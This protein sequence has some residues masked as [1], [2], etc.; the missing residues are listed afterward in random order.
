MA[1][2]GLLDIELSVPD[3]TALASFWERRGMILTA[4]DVLG[5]ADRPV[6]LRVAE[7]S[8]RHLSMLHL[9]CET[10]ADLAVIAGR[11]GDLGVDATIEDT[12]LRCVDPVFGHRVVIDVGAPPPLSPTQ[13]RAYNHPGEQL[14]AG[15]RA[16]AVAEN[17]PRPP[18]RL[19]HVVLGTPKVA[20]AT[21][22]FI[23][24]L[25]YR[26]SD[27]VL[28]GVATFARV[29]T[30]HHNLLIHPGPCGHLNHYAFEMDD[31]DAVGKAGMGVLAERNDASIVGVGR[32]NLGANIFWYMT[33][34]AGNMFEFFSDMDQIV[35]DEAWERDHCKRDWE[36]TDGPAGFSVWGPKEP[37]VF[38]NQ[39][40]LA[41]I[42]AAREALGLE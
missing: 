7:G 35:D 33:D 30:D 20:E 1:L 13:I 6:Q 31:V 24:G 42:G 9:S 40:D 19:G 21:A 17:S 29:E 26:I 36:G 28:N 8:Y 15:V 16:D 34:P 25:G 23:D 39:P 18:R 11:I 2:N 14:R 5:T 38:F 3:P 32:H 4:D 22:F 37:E 12:T 10:E 41:E 27:Q